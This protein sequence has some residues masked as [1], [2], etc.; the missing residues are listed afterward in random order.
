M[1]KVTK[2]MW[3]H[4][5][6]NPVW[7]CIEVDQECTNCYA[8]TF[9]HRYGFD[10]WG[11]EKTTDRRTFG[12]KHWNQPL[13]WNRE[14]GEAEEVKRVFCGSMCDIMEDHAVYKDIRPTVYNLTKLTDYL[15]W[16]MLTKRP[17]NFTKYLPHDWLKTP[18]K[19]IWYGTSVGYNGS[20]HRI[21]EL[22]KVPANIRFLSCE[23][24]IDNLKLTKQDLKGIHWVIVGGESGA[25]HR[26]CEL[27]WI[28]DVVNACKDNGVPVFVK[29]MG[30]NL[31]KR[32]NLN[33]SKGE[34]ITE[35]PKHLRIQQFPKSF[36]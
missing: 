15:N 2:I 21:E 8:K 9:S 17:E 27:K 26:P 25:K 33:H 31:A 35:F 23:P 28:E 13:K 22:K 12:E 10:V 24:L 5:T 14:A 30:S 6:F 34:D 7:G 11:P 16:L 18:P 1:G 32:M 4:H 36:I 19:N 20:K 3:T 29:Q